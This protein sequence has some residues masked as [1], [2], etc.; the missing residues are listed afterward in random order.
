ML[1]SAAIFLMLS[2]GSCGQDPG[3]A[4]NGMVGPKVDE[5]VELLAIA[6][7]LAGLQGFTDSSNPRYAAAIDQAFASQKNHALVKHLQEQR[8]LIEPAPWEIPA[9]AMHLSQTPKLEPL[10]KP[11]D[12]SNQDEWES[13]TL[14]TAKMVSLLQAF[15][16]DSQAGDFFKSQSAY[17]KKVEGEYA[18]QGKLVDVNWFKNFF[19]NAPSE[20][21]EPVLAIS[22]RQGAYMRINFANNRRNTATMF[23]TNGFD[24]SGV[25]TNLANPYIPKMIVHETVHCFTNQIVDK[26]L[27]AFEKVGKKLYAIPEVK[28]KVSG[29]FYDNWPYLMYESLVRAG[30]IKYWERH[31]GII[32]SREAAVA[33]EVNAG[34]LWMDGLVRE[35]DRFEANRGKYKTIEDFTPE[36][37][38]FFEKQVK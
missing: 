34:F 13:R 36:L 17:Y 37:L 29:S 33:T 30:S 14:L 19:G 21:Y 16:K 22:L 9:L 6:C 38:A 4:A 27:A 10:M 31:P 23:E 18:K 24:A 20:V 25:P 1:R 12:D 32:A 26:N 5:R 15:Y 28:Q 8:E 7:R 3:V 2:L 11:G 35:L